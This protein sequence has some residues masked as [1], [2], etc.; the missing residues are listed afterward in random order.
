MLQGVSE[1]CMLPFTRISTL[2][3]TQGLRATVSNNPYHDQHIKEITEAIDETV[4]EIQSHYDAILLM[5]QQ[6]IDDLNARVEQLEAQS[7][8]PQTV[9]VF[10]R[11]NMQS[12]KEVREK[13]I[14][15][16]KF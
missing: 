2:R 5:M 15:M 13:I 8:K 14:K 9:D 7:K 3:A 10:A 11:L 4:F 6:Q 16:L 12:I 1:F